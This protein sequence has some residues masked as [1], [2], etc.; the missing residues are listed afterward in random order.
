[1]VNLVALQCPKCGSNLQVEQGRSQYFCSYCGAK[2]LIQNENEY[3]YRIVD[4]ARIKEAELNA[5]IYS[6]E[7]ELEAQEKK[8]QSSR[9]FFK[10]RIIIYVVM[11]AIGTF[12][13]LALGIHNSL[14]TAFG[15]VG[16]IGYIALI[17]GSI[18]HGIIL[19]V[20]RRK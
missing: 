9:N 15:M 7:L 11:S 17:Y 3:V 14:G 4:E 20:N 8:C 18:I 5:S 10:K 13:W 2:I 12:L 1:M 19:L 16:T 6:K